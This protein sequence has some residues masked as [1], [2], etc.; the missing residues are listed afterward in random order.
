MKLDRS[1]VFYSKTTEFLKDLEHYTGP[2]GRSPSPAKK[3]WLDHPDLIKAVLACGIP[4]N[5]IYAFAKQNELPV[6]SE[7]TFTGWVKEWRKEAHAEALAMEA[8]APHES[9]NGYVPDAEKVLATV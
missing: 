1:D 4:Q 5:R 3:F 2:R 9:S 7:S 6:P 8:I